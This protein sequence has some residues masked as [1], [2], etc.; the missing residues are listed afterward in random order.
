[1]TEQIS[2]EAVEAGA[3][4][5]FPA[6]FADNLASGEDDRDEARRWTLAGLRAAL[7]HLVQPARAVP[8]VE[9]MREVAETAMTDDGHRMPRTDETR[10]LAHAAARAIAALLSAAPTVAD[11][12]EQAAR[13]IEVLD[14]WRNDPQVTGLSDYALGVRDAARIARGE[15]KGDDRG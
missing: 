5:T 2:A 9:E 15:K 4:A 7:P 6:H 12:R 1:M 14:P 3:R 11:V 13:E 8:S 10:Y